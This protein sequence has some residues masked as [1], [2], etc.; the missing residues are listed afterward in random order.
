MGVFYNVCF[1]RVGSLA[2]DMARYQ[3]TKPDQHVFVASG[4][5]KEGPFSATAKAEVK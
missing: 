5:V 2:T 1:G 3:A 4:C